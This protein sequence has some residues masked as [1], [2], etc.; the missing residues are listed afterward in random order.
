MQPCMTLDD[1]LP[2]S[3]PRAIRRYGGIKGLQITARS[4][5]VQK[6]R[7]AGFHRRHEELVIVVNRERIMDGSFCLIPQK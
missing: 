1:F 2:R 3:R 6:A 7:R 4:G 5:L